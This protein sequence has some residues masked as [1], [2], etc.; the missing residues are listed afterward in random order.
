[1]RRS[2]VMTDDSARHPFLASL[3]PHVRRGTPA[4]AIKHEKPRWS[5]GDMKEFLMAYC[6]CFAAVTIFI[7]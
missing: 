5:F 7:A 2:L 6:A 1:M 3:P 4:L